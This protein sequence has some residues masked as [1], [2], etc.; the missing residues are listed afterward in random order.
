VR[1][2][3]H[4][5]NNHGL[6]G[7]GIQPGAGRKPRLTQLKRSA[8]LALVQSP[9]AGKPTYERSGEL[10]TLDPEGES[11]WTLDTLTLAAQ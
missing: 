11:E 8:I 7:L 6:D 9:P 1:H 5:F 10:D 3:I 2:R 4:T